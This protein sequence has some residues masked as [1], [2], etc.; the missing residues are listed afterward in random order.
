MTASPLIFRDKLPS[1]CPPSDAEEICASRE[2]FRAVVSFP[3]TSNDFLSQRQE[4]PE[5]V[6]NGVSE[7]NARGLSVFA[8]QR[9][10]ARALKLPRLRGRKLCKV[11]LE[12]GAGK[13]QQTFNPSHHTWWPFASFDI[14]SHCEEVSS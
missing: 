7:C 10:C 6:F 4:N 11:R 3:P 14:L 12:A 13:I 5:R 9:D 2:V 8:E 1:E